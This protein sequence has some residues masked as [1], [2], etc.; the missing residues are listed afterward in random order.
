MKLR[1][2]ALP[3]TLT[4]VALALAIHAIGPPDASAGAPSTRLPAGPPKGVS[5]RPGRAAVPSASASAASSGEPVASFDLPPLA[6]ETLPTERSDLP[7]AD[8][9]KTAPRVEITR[10]SPEARWCRAFRVREYLKVHCGMPT[11]GIRQLAGNPKDVQLFVVPKTGESLFNPPQG[12]QVI[13]PL[14]RTEARLFQFFRTVPGD[15]DGAVPGASIMVD[16]SWPEGLAT[17]TVVLR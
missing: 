6:K 2:L 5:A 10:R 11:A 1:R 4:V 16:S 12:G 9:W 13:F 3:G 17:P 14:R 7:S 15:Y 8:E